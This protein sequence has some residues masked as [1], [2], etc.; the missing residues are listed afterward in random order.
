MDLIEY[1][2]LDLPNHLAALV[3]HTPQD[4]RGHHKTSRIWIDRHISSDQTDITK[5]R[6]KLSVFLVRESF[7][8]RG[9]DHTT[10]LLERH[11]D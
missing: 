3:N 10:V 11:G 6:L 1:D 7:D 2:P 4:F 8:R 5:F 9:I